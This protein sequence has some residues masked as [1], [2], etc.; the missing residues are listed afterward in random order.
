M[1]KRLFNIFYKE[2][3]GLHEAAYL[4]AF[5]SFLSQL[6]ALLRDRILAS[7]FGA[8]NTL[9]IYYSSFRIPDFVFVTVASIVSISVLVPFI[10]EK[11]HKNENDGK[12]FISNIFISFSFLI[13]VTSIIFYFL[14]P[15][16]VPKVFPGMKNVSELINMSRI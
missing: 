6:L 15:F 14:I 3:K 4:L 1:V 12:N 2:I 9:D 8:G 10:N 16:L 5:F 11:V 13:I 7:N